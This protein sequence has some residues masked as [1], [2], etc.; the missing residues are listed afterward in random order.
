M[1]LSDVCR[2]DSRLELDR[3]FRISASG[4]GARLLAACGAGACLVRSLFVRDAGGGDG[5]GVA[6]LEDGRMGRDCGVAGNADDMGAGGNAGELSGCTAG[7]GGECVVSSF[8]FQVEG[9]GF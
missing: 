5:D 4:I 7:A 1:G 2:S 3:I 9:F 8:R 6:H